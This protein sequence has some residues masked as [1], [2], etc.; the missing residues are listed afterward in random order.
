MVRI[1]IRSRATWLV[2]SVVFALLVLGVIYHVKHRVPVAVLRQ[3]GLSDAASGNCTQAVSALK[4]VV[5]ADNADISAGEALGSCYAAMFQFNL[6]LPILSREAKNYPSVSTYMN[7]GRVAYAAGNTV[8][9]RNALVSALNT[10]TNSISLLSV[11]S[12]TESFGFS[13][14]SQEAL[15]KIP[16]KDRGSV[17]YSTL[18]FDQ[19]G[20]GEGALAIKSETM[21]I[22]LSSGSQTGSELATLGNLLAQNFQCS[23]AI[24]TL[25]AALSYKTNFSALPSI[26]SKIVSCAIQIGNQAQALQ[27]A[28]KAVAIPI[29]SETVAEYFQARLTEAQI[30]ASMNN[31]IKAKQLLQNILASKLIPNNINSSAQSLLAQISS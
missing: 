20:M 12:A 13:R 10:A 9:C 6:A 17:W 30:Y 31:S 7:L 18:S 11:A 24:P 21:A 27:Y 2:A 22:H 4:P 19:N 3:R 23:K 14:L 5:A 29:S 15:N 25:T 28:Q 1:A 8:E 26:Y 16:L